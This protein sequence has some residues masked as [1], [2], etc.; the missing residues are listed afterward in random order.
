M[1]HQLPPGVRLTGV[2]QNQ[3]QQ[4]HH[5]Q[6]HNNSLPLPQQHQTLSVSNFMSPNTGSF[7]FN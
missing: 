3:Q 6:P 1:G 5:Q 2:S 7:Q 4:F